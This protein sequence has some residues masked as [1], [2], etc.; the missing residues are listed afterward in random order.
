MA[1]RIRRLCIRRGEIS[2]RGR[3]RG[4]RGPGKEEKGMYDKLKKFVKDLFGQTRSRTDIKKG[5]N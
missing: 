4:P 1:R 5:T 2:R 3:T